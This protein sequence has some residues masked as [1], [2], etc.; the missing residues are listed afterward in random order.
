M[1][2][3]TS[4]AQVSVLG[5]LVEQPPT[6]GSGGGLNSTMTVALPGGALVNGASVNVQFVLGMQQAGSFRFVVN[7]EALP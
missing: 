4:G 6:Q 1:V 7:C 3:L 5:T 2:T